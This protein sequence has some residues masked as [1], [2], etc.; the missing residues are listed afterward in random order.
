MHEN[1]S[2]SHHL[3]VTVPT[4]SRQ[5]HTS[6][7][8]APGQQ[9][10]APGRALWR[11]PSRLLLLLQLRGAQ[12]HR[13]TRNLPCAG[14]EG[15]PEARTSIA[16]HPRPSP[17]QGPAPHRPPAPDR[18]SSPAPSSAR[19]GRREGAPRPRTWRRRRGWETRPRRSM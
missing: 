11:G 4:A 1:L 19:V 3:T 6:T 7:R 18:R 16:R 9:T 8:R 14:T 5:P 10:A 2:P 12:R 17:P 13:E 15:H